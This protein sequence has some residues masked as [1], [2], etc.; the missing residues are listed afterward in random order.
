MHACM[1]QVGGYTR[2]KVQS[3]GGLLALELIALS[4]FPLEKYVVPVG[5][6]VLFP[7]P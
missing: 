3:L 4:E 1:W 7:V 2:G 5:L 6:H